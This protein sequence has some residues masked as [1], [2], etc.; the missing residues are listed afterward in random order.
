VGFVFLE[1][2]ETVLETDVFEGFEFM[3]IEIINTGLEAFF[4]C[5]MVEI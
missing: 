4:E 2:L 5:E 1:M 3:L